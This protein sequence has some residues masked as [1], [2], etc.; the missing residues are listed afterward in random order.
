MDT[1]NKELANTLI[2]TENIIWD[3]YYNGQN[4]PPFDDKTEILEHTIHGSEAAKIWTCYLP[5][6]Y[7]KSI[8][9][10][11][12]DYDNI[13]KITLYNNSHVIDVVHSWNMP[14]LYQIY[15]VD[16]KEI[17]LPFDQ[18]MGKNYLITNNSRIVVDFKN[19][20]ENYSLR[21]LYYDELKDI[22]M[23]K[24]FWYSSN[25]YSVRNLEIS[26][27]SA[28]LELNLTHP[29]FCLYFK[30]NLRVE[31]I[32]LEVNNK[33]FYT[34]DKLT[35]N[36]ENS[37]YIVPLS[38]NNILQDYDLKSTPLNAS[39]A[40]IIILHLNFKEYHQIITDKIVI[41]ALAYKNMI[42][43]S[44][45]LSSTTGSNKTAIGNKALVANDSTDNTF[46]GMSS[47]LHNTIGSDKVAIGRYA[48]LNNIAGSNNV[49]IG[50][51][52]LSLNNG[53]NNVTTVYNGLLDNTT[54]SGK[55]AMGNGTLL[56][57]TTGS[58]KVAIGNNAL[59]A[60]TTGSNK[61]AI[62]NNALLANTTGS[63][64]VAIGSNTL[65]ANTTGSGKF[66]LNN[67]ALSANTTGSNM[68]AIGRTYHNRT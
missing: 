37:V 49:A 39:Q 34:T 64:K 31:S 41:C 30:I 55:V 36:A 13:D 16:T 63:N 17:M 68:V 61:V 66:A 1:L 67:N 15:K 25:L 2:G 19:T 29:I 54:G 4:L 6:K 14:I 48:L 45:L 40:E 47:S 24:Y 58:G 50:F 18:V 42:T 10:V 62:G 56:A 44:A 46:I 7:I 27:N 11:V 53:S 26:G 20:T 28:K 33:I 43:S 8:Y 5:H 65:L 32:M 21:Y 60:N 12:D 38:F 35:Y 22:D 57:N 23:P 52:A 3:K 59:L 9:L 51:E